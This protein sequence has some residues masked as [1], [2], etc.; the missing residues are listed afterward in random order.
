METHFRGRA[1]AELL[2]EA[3]EHVRGALELCDA[4]G[5]HTAACHLQFGN[6]LLALAATEGAEGKRAAPRRG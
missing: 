6:D 2:A 5:E 4:L 3:I 1:R